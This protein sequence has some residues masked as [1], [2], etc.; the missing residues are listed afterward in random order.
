MKISWITI[1]IKDMERSLQFYTEIIGMEMVSRLAPNDQMEIAF[2]GK[3]GTQIELIAHRDLER[4]Q[5][6]E[7]LSIGF[8]LD[9]MSIDEFRKQHSTIG[10]E[11][12]FQ[13]NEHL[14]FIYIKDPA[15]VKIQLVE[16]L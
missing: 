7:Q 1:H 16:T 3:D 14:R 11:G 13:P 6:P 8:M 12:P 4:V 10:V 2:L 5:F 15:G 9:G